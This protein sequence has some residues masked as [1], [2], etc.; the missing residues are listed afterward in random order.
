MNELEQ[1]YSIA[2]SMVPGIPK[3]VLCD[4]IKQAG[5]AVEAYDRFSVY[6]QD[7]ELSVNLVEQVC[8]MKHYLESAKRELEFAWENDIQV[9]TLMDAAY[10]SRMR[11]CPD[12]PIILYYKGCADINALRMVAMVGTRRCT[13]NGRDFCRTFLR[14]LAQLC[15]DV[16]IVSGLAYGIDVNAHMQALANGLP[17]VAVLAHG[18]D[19]LYPSSHKNIA[20]EMI[21]NG[22]LITEFMN[23]TTMD[24]FHF[25]QRNRIVA[26]LCDATIVVESKERGGSLI[27]AEL[28]GMYFRD[29]F[30][31][32]GRV[33]DDC[34]KGCNN[35]IQ[36]NAAVLLQSAEGFVKSM[37][38]ESRT[39]PKTPIQ[40]NLFV[41]L[42][43]QEVEVVN[44]LRHSEPLDLS[45]LAVK[46][47]IPIPHLH[48]IL[49]ELELK[50]VVKCLVGG[51]YRLLD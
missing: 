31:C 24:K 27:T 23:G 39:A 7:G 22:G 19:T 13:E 20:N 10:S 1:L 11:E 29:V 35:M 18:L 14:D 34:S 4:L 32:P 44:K 45:N 33:T 5:S 41:D 48:E 12:A 49:F 51:H 21:R 43:P 9:L 3:T 47:N 16:V 37:N 42:T 38:W 26:G 28:A 15:P 8:Q 36:N 6:Q 17:T 2:F 50:G 40:R 46:C 30:A 25:V